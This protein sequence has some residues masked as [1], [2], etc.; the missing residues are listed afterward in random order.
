M[1]TN[2]TKSLR[3]AAAVFAAVLLVLA[4]LGIYAAS[5]NGMDDAVVVSGDFSLDNTQLA[6]FY[7]SEYFYFSGAYGDY[8]DGLV[9]FTKPLSQQSY[10]EDQSWEDYLLEETLTT[11]RETMAMVFEAETQGYTL[12]QEGQDE[13][14]AVLESFREAAETGGYE[15]LD[16]YLQASYGSG[17]NEASFTEYL[18][19]SYLASE[20]ADSLYEAIDPTEDEILAYYENHAGEYLE[21]YG[22]TKDDPPVPAGVYL[23]FSTAAEAQT[24]YGTFLEGGA[25][26]ELLDNLGAANQGKTG[27]LS[28]VTPD[29]VGEAAADWFYDDSRQPGDHAVVEEEDGSAAI[30]YYVAPGEEAYWHILAR[31]DARH[32]AYQNTYLTIS[33][34]YT[35]YVNYDKVRLTPPEGLYEQ[36]GQTGEETESE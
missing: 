33:G 10:S 24:V 14:D 11:V 20:Y 19:W 32:E 2:S 35:F 17:A 5:K 36:A 18:G 34:S 4:G 8:L 9:D 1:G 30:C 23:S 12:S 29:A 15:T 22:V 31:E 27:E 13:L 3:A 21:N 6:Y 16:G 28:Q 26:R 25:T 7:W